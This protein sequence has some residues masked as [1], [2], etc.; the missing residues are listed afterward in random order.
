MRNLHVV[1]LA[2]LVAA[3]CSKSDSTDKGRADKPSAAAGGLAWQPEGMDKLTP[4]CLKALTCCEAVVVAKNPSATASDYNLSCSGAASGTWKD[5]DCTTDAK[6]R[7]AE[8]GDKAPM[9]CK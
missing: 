1:L 6:S 2:V 4:A 3:G 5:A 9:S 7:G 8:L